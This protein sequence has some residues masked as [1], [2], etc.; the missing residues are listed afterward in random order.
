[1]SLTRF[2]HYRT[3]KISGAFS[4]AYGLG[5]PMLNHAAL[6]GVAELQVASLFHD[7]GGLVERLNALAAAP[8]ELED[9]RRRMAAYPGFAVDVQLRRYAALAGTAA[10]HTPRV[11]TS[12]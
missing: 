12:S 3:S 5:V 4:L 2:A 1:M 11:T 9:V 8:G 10:D 7:D 6:A